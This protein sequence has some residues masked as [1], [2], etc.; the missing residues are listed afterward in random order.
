MN[1]ETITLGGGCF[2]CLETVFN[3]IKGVISVDSGYSGGTV[4]APTYEQ[5]C[6]GTT[7]HAEVVRVTFDPAE[8]PVGELLDLFFAFHDPTTINRQG[9]DVGEQYRSAIFAESDEQFR[10]AEAKVAEL[11]AAGYFELPIVTQLRRLEQFWP[12]EEYHRQYYVLHPEQAYCRS[13]IAP[14]VA[15]LRAGYASRLKEGS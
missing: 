5:V 3:R 7:G 9:V 10:A 14:K 1:H 8:L 12:A 2:W 13:S 6:S 11:E 15:K 4:P